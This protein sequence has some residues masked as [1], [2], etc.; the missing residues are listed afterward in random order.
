MTFETVHLPVTDDAP[1]KMTAVGGTYF[2][3][4]TLRQWPVRWMRCLC[5]SA[6]VGSGAQQPAVTD[7]VAG[8]RIALRQL[9]L[10]NRR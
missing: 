9:R 8:D 2:N 5:E 3:S 1:T 10:I 4:A 6:A 7:E